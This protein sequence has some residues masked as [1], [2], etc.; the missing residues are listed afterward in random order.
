MVPIVVVF[1]GIPG[2]SA[3]TGRHVVGEWRPLLVVLGTSDGRDS[4]FSRPLVGLG[5]VGGSWGAWKHLVVGG[6]FG[7]MSRRVINQPE[8][9]QESFIC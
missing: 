6:L 1:I 8:G 5:A 9:H 4:Q 2:V 3:G 7:N